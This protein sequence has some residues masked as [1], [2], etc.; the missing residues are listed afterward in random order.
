MMVPEHIS[1][2]KDSPD[3]KSRLSNLLLMLRSKPD[4]GS[5]LIKMSGDDDT[6]LRWTNIMMEVISGCE[7]ACL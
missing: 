6:C 3:D 7:L 1:T 4:G 2:V 5:M